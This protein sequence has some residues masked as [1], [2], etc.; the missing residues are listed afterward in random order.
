MGS[1]EIDRLTTQQMI[2]RHNLAGSALS[3]RMKALG[4]EPQEI[5]GRAFY[6]AAQVQ[7]LDEL[8][9]FIQQGGNTAQF[10]ELRG[11]SKQDINSE[12]F[13]GLLTGESDL[14]PL[15]NN[16]KIPPSANRQGKT[17]TGMTECAV[18]QIPRGSPI[19]VFFSYSR[20]DKPLRDE[21]EKHLSSLRRRGVISSWHDRQIAAGAEWEK[22]IDAHLQSADIILLLISPA[23]IYSDYCYEIELPN[24]LARHDAGEAC[25]VPILLRPVEGWEDLPFAR[26]QVYPSGGKPVTEWDRPDSAYVDIAKGIRSAVEQLLEKRRQQEQKLN[27]PPALA[28]HRSQ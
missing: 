7:Q 6:S 27:H 9:E 17:G 10:V 14:F 3:R 26:L 11:I 28:P 21:L 25:V 8:H 5:E 4:I 19:T 22:E 15:F 18:M 2:E 12:E 1:G 13:T 24:A 23:F 16:I 20:E